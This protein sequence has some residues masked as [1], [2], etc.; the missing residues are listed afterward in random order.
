MIEAQKV[1]RTFTASIKHQFPNLPGNSTVLY[2]L[3]NPWQWQAL[4][5]GEAIKTIY[6]DQT[7][8]IYYNEEGLRNDYCKG[9]LKGPIY[10]YEE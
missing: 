1:G 9:K 4:S 6:N 10:I 3:P 8:G 2:Y 7:L 5:Y